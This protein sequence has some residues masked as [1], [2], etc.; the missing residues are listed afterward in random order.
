MICSGKWSFPCECGGR[1]YHHFRGNQCVPLPCDLSVIWRNK[2]TPQI[3]MICETS[4][5][6]LANHWGSV[7]RKPN[8]VLSAEMTWGTEAVW[9]ALV[10]L[11][12]DLQITAL[13][14]TGV[15]QG[16]FL[17]SWSLS[18]LLAKAESHSL[19][20]SFIETL[21]FGHPLGGSGWGCNDEQAQTVPYE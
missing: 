13:P 9:A 4:T 5:R 16:Q 10:L 15:P 6:I 19:I 20:A 12:A 1:V 14:L 21:L 8:H 3:Q 17:P 11:E 2:L 18:S 7:V